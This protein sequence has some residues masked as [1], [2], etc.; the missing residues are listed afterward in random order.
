MQLF[1]DHV[2]LPVTTEFG[3]LVFI[4]KYT[5]GLYE[6]QNLSGETVELLLLASS[7]GGDGCKVMIRLES[8][9]RM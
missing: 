1:F 8:M 4:P 6:P 7:T 2:N 9:D 5:C 3:L